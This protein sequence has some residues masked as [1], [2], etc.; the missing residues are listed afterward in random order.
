MCLAATWESSAMSMARGLD[1]HA[2]QL[3]FAQCV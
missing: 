1:D 2:S 3:Q